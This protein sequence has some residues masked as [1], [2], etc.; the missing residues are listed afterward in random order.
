VNI[1]H[2]IGAIAGNLNPFLGSENGVM[3][4]IPAA[5]GVIGSDVMA[6]R[7]QEKRVLIETSLNVV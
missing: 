2:R 6:G 7:I 1:C 3:T 5:H 4:E